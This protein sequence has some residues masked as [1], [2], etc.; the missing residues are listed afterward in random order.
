MMTIKIKSWWMHVELLDLSCWFRLYSAPKIESC[1]CEIDTLS[2]NSEWN[3]W[4]RAG[5]GAVES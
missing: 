5:V 1:V 2:C 4:S 3:I